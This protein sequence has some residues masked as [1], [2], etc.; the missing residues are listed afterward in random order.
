MKY[1]C[2]LHIHSKYSRGTSKNITIENLSKYAKIKG[3]HILGTGDFTHPEWFSQLKEKLEEKEEKGV[4]YLKKQDT[5]NKLLNYCDTQTTEEETRE[6]GFIFQTEISLMYSDAVKSRKIH[7]VIL[8][9]NIPVT[10]EIN[11]YF[12]SKGRMDY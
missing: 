4:Y 8:S 5:Q 7:I 12:S 6:T 2:D 3:L 11:K 1:F 10:E 9:P